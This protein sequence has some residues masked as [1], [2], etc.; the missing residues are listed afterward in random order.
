MA[1]IGTLP[2]PGQKPWDL[3]PA[4]TAM[5]NELNGLG[6]RFVPSFVAT[7]VTYDSNN[8]VASVTEDGITTTF[9]YNLDG[10]VATDTRLGKTRTYT[11]DTAGNLTAIGAPA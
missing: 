7:G 6:Q 4:I 11:Y 2:E 10:T 8:N 1:D 3:R 9:T 5:N